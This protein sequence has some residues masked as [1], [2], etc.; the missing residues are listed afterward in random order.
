MRFV[1]MILA[2]GVYGISNALGN[3]LL[4]SEEAQEVFIAILAIAFIMDIVDFFRGK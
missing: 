4:K 1:I 2:N 3:N